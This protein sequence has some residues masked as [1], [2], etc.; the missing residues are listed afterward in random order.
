MEREE[1]S[2]KDESGHSEKQQDLDV[3]IKAGEWQNL[4]RFKTYQ[5]RSRQ[6][7]IIATYQAVSNRLNQLVALYYKFAAGNPAKASKLLEELRRLRF[8]QEILLNCL[9]WEQEDQLEDKEVPEEV[10][11]LIK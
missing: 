3:E 4:K 1:K 6:G 11:N 9:I 8:L 7:K 2:K 10:W 5:N